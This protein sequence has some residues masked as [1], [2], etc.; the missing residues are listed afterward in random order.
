[1]KLLRVIATVDPATGG[2]VAGL[3]AVTPELA[4]LGHE[5]EFLTV[6]APTE[7][8]LESW[9]GRVHALG[10]VHNR[11][12][13][14]PRLRAWLD[15]NLAQYDAVVVHGLWQDLGRT[16]RAACLRRGGPPYFV[17][18]H[19]M[20]DPGLRK[21]YPIRHAKK[22]LYWLLIERRV[23]RDARAVLFTCEEERRLARQSFPG[24]RC[25]EEVITYGAAVPATGDTN[26]GVAWQARCPTANGR[27]FW[28][29]L[30]RVHSK[31]GVDLLL[32]AYAQVRRATA[33]NELRNFPDLVIA[34]PCLDV[35]YLDQLKAIAAEN[36]VTP[37][38]H[39]VGMLTGDAKWGALRSAEAF[40]LPSHQENFGIAVVEAL[41]NGKPVL[42]SDR[43]NI[44]RELVADGAAL[45][46]PD[47][48]AGVASL[49]RRWQALPA[50]AREAMA[51]SAE[52]SYKKRFEIAH[53]AETFAA[54]L[55][56]LLNQAKPAIP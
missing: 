15:K 37:F 9:V 44:W 21:T 53:A 18:P 48:A 43:V 3:R 40:V 23:L 32:Q 39:W 7:P 5:T 38:V 24:Y 13:R 28:L 30:G 17:F 25:N 1:M 33:E 6:D 12:A 31:K 47:D 26:F 42:I 51:A 54:Q 56:G 10:P 20:L 36:A 16:V 2:P 50:A 8:F 34:G 52:Q 41:A 11:Y 27:R 14:S 46:E 35:A 55:A 19:G 4:S 49:L 22:W 29:F 45:V